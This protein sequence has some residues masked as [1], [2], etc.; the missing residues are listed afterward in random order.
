MP[1]NQHHTEYAPP[2]LRAPSPA[3]SIGT[4]YG[5]DQ[6]ELSDSEEQLSHIDFEKK[7]QERLQLGVARQEEELANRDP[8]L[9]RAQKGSPEE[10]SESQ[11]G[12]Y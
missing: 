11:R 5:Q 4:T 9:I 8:L 2:V 10:K 12:V 6:T 3:S 1:P 7:V